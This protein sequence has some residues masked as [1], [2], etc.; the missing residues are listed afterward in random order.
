MAHFKISYLVPLSILK[1]NGFF[2]IR[3]CKYK[4]VYNIPRT[5]PPGPL[6]LSILPNTQLEYLKKY[7][8]F[9]K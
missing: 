3:K 5:C 7:S 6:N 2:P 9:I 1:V 8:T 4:Y